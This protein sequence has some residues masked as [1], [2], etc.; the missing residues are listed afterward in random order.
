MQYVMFVSFVTLCQASAE[1]ICLNVH[2]YICPI[3]H[4]YICDK[5]DSS[6]C[7]LGGDRM[8]RVSLCSA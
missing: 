2:E 3:V 8:C 5:C 1:Y 4:E 6:E 7:E